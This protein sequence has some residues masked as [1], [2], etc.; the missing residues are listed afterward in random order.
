MALKYFTEYRDFSESRLVRIEIDSPNY[1]GTPIELIPADQ[2]LII[3]RQ[4]NQDD[5]PFKAHI[6]NSTA[7]IQVFSDNLDVNELMLVNDASY[8]TRVY[9]NNVL[10]WQGFIIS[11]GI[12]E[13][14]SGV[15]YP[16]TIKAIDGLELLD[17]VIF[18]WADNY[19]RII[20][21]GVTS[22]QRCPM[23]AIRLCLFASANLDNRLPIRWS[24][25]L[26]NFQYF[27]QDAFA[28]NTKLNPF[29]ELSLSAERS[30]F[31][32]VKNICQSLGCWL[33]QQDGYWY[34]VNYA[35]LINNNGTLDFW[36]ITSQT[37]TVETAVKV[38]L[39]MNVDANNLDTDNIPS[40]WV[41]K[42]LGGVKVIYQNITD[43][44]NVLP[45]GN[46]DRWSLGG[47]VDWG[48]EPRAN[49]APSLLQYESLF[50]RE[51]SSVQLSNDGNATD[52][53]VF[54][55]VGSIAV[56]SWKLFK[57]FTFG[58]T[59]SPSK[60][61][62][63]YNTST[64]IIDWSNNPLKISVSYTQDGT[65]WYMNEFGFWQAEGR[66]LNLGTRFVRT[67]SEVF[68]FPNYTEYHNMFF[69]GNANVGDTLEVKIKSKIG[70]N[71]Y[72]TYSFTVTS[73]E[74]GNLELALYG[75]MNAL[76]NSID[77]DNLG[78]KRVTMESSTLGYVRYSIYFGFGDPICSTYKSGNTQEFRYI[79]PFVQNMKI[80][81][82]AT[83]PFTGK[84]GNSEILLPEINQYD[85]LNGR[86]QVQ[87]FVRIGQQYVLDDVYIKVPNNNDVYTIDLNGSKNGKDEYIMEIGS[88]FS[89]HLLSSYGDSY[90]DRNL[91]MWWNGGTKTLP[92]LYGEMIM[93]WRSK[94]CRVFEG[95]V[96]G[97]IGWGLLDI[98]GIKYVPLTITYNAKDD[99]SSVTAIEIRQE[100]GSYNVLHRSSDDKA[101]QNGGG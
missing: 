66:G 49:D 2:P 82:V 28:G 43:E 12:R 95:D 14:D 73:V 40:Y 38:T 48:F 76:P 8:K 51:G 9:V 70:S 36:Q 101:F 1:T 16:V 83:I 21:D 58:F 63:N 35:D 50:Q 7:Q 37:S 90:Q 27:F 67:D 69:E 75:L 54:T 74:E 87:F 92:Q 77:G 10:D 61:G 97:R 60:Y 30:A 52:E 17:N 80:N 33:F 24:C 26:K 72:N 79:Y 45:N 55:H 57:S 47:L 3:E 88:S 20:V 39:D 19:P 11:D 100:V 42:P 53:A 64:E 4:G 65:T 44:N 96:E 25:S 41:K 18:T 84:G 68:P 98:R 99:V 13:K 78:A 59:F 5:D 34:I 56:D 71:V 31:W 6:I 89:G 91:S 85:T 62:F 32:W 81:D 86:I 22:A 23:N 93:N 15:A 29:G 94:P 46:F